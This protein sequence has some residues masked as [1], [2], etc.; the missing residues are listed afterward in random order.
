M[1]VNK[2]GFI[3]TT[4]ATTSTLIDTLEVTAAKF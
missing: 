2:R 3:K 1:I 4:L